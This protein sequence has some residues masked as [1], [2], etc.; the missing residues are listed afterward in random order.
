MQDIKRVGILKK[1]SV[2]DLRRRNYI[3]RYKRKEKGTM[4]YKDITNFEEVRQG[5][6]HRKDSNNIAYMYICTMCEG[7]FWSSEKM[8]NIPYYRVRSRR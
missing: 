8:L 4:S 3:F 5:K 7:E 1:Y 6:K 2:K